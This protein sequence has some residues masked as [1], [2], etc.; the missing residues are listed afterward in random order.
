MPSVIVQPPY[1][2]ATI[3]IVH[4]ADWDDPMPA[5]LENG[6]P[7]N[8]TGKQLDLWIRPVYDHS[9]L[10]RRLSSAASLGGEIR[11]DNAAAGLASIYV[12]RVTVRTE[13]P[14]G[15]WDHFLVLQEVSGDTFYREVFRGRLKVWP[16]KTADSGGGFS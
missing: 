1:T 9:V 15:E 8:L 14:I 10:L 4:D 5:I 13:L 2:Q 3:E 16:G 12:P 6:A 7:L 11:F